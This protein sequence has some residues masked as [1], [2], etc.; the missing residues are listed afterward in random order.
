MKKLAILVA[1][2]VLALPVLS[3]AGITG[4]TID[5]TSGTG[6][7]ESNPVDLT[8]DG[9]L[10]WGVWNGP[11]DAG[12]LTT[13]FETKSG[14]TAFQ[15]IS[16]INGGGMNTSYGPTDFLFSWTDGTAGS[17]DSTGFAYPQFV[18]D[19]GNGGVQLSFNIAEAGAYRLNF[20]V[21]TYDYVLDATATLGSDGTPVTELSG[22]GLGTLDDYKFTVDFT[23]SGADTLD[24]DIIG[25]SGGAQIGVAEAF[26]LEA[27]PEPATFG[28]IGLFGGGLLLARR[29]FMI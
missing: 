8:A 29:L 6:N 15:G 4:I 14:G 25:Q 20:Y 12:N 2:G 1:A 10:D 21:A 7:D 24:L 16:V 28:L 22:A 11:A 13:L 17:G 3:Q 5:V 18:S 19:T 23:T 27:I 26:T 9:N